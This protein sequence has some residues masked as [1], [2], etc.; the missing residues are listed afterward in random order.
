MDKIVS[1]AIGMFISYIRCMLTRP[2]LTIAF[3]AAISLVLRYLFTIN[4]HICYR[5]KHG[6]WSDGTCYCSKKDI[7]VPKQSMNKPCF[8]WWRKQYDEHRHYC[9][10]CKYA[11]WRNHSCFCSKFGNIRNI[12]SRSGCIHWDGKNG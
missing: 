9:D 12:K 3:I 5:C 7:M 1:L 4:K 10:T 6:E 8:K 11:I 2:I